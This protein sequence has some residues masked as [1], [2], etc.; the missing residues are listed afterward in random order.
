MK[1]GGIPTIIQAMKNHPE[2][3]E[4]LELASNVFY[5]LSFS[6]G[7]EKEVLEYD[8]VKPIV[9]SI[10]QHCNDLN[11]LHE[12]T[13]TLGRLY[14]LCDEIGKKLIIKEGAIEAIVQALKIHPEDQ[15]LQQRACWSFFR[16]AKD[17]LL[18]EKIP[19]LSTPSLKEFCGRTLTS[20]I[21]NNNNNNNNNNM[22]DKFIKSNNNQYLLPLELQ[23]YLE[24]YRKCS[25]CGKTFFDFHFEFIKFVKFEE[26]TAELP[27]FFNLC[28]FKCFKDCKEK[29]EEVKQQQQRQQ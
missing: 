29:Q 8:G 5:D 20:H 1:V 28:S 24:E 13:R 10:K 18:H 2:Y 7:A 3:P 4:L 15:E 14:S 27:L 19:Q 26:H 25:Q 16:M 23:D 17:K 9:N 12:S 21:N 6:N 22:N 11:V